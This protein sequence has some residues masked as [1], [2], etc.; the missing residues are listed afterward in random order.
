MKKIIFIAVLLLLMPYAKAAAN[1]EVTA[2]SCNPNEV[3]INNQFSC[4]ATIQNTGD[5][6][7]TLNTAT[8]YPDS[9]SWME[10]ASYAET[11]N[12]VINSGASTDVVF[13]GLK[14]KKSG[15]NGFTKIMLDD[16]TDTYVADTAA[17]VNV[18]NVMSTAT[19]SASSAG[20]SSNVDVTGQATVGGNVD[21]VLSFSVSSG[22]CS[23]GSQSSTAASN[24]M[25]NGQTTSR[26]WTVTMGSATCAY[27]VSAAATSNP[28]GTATKTDSST[29]SITCSDCTSTSSSSTSSSGGGGGGGGGG[30]AAGA[31]E[32]SETKAVVTESQSVAYITAGQAAVFS[33]SKS[34]QLAVSEIQIEAKNTVSSV[35][36]TLTEASKPASASLPVE[37]STGSVYKYVEIIVKNIRTEDIGKAFVSFTVPKT[38]IETNA[39]DPET[40]ALKR[41]KGS[42][43]DSLPT[44]RL[45]EDGSN[46]YYKAETPGFSAFAI[47]AEKRAEKTAETGQLAGEKAKGEAGAQKGLPE[48]MEIANDYRAWIAIAFVL[49]AIIGIFGYLHHHTKKQ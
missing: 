18:I 27:S 45:S 1:L 26:T 7:G 16:V 10:S 21:I 5:A 41:L 29:G 43:W 3:V 47:T 19:S 44:T 49:M 17:K 31:A 15:N 6:G 46:Y 33:F 39:L 20:S 30:A 12:S 40:T 9:S 8:L 36:V 22:G 4:T 25:T 28:S 34:A 2:F 11:S 13:N 23:I 48:L 14:G 38:W 42:A 37:S 35:I 24:E 32:K